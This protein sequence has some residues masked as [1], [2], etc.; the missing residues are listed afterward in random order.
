MAEPVSS[1]RPSNGLRRVFVIATIAALTLSVGACGTSGRALR[2]PK[3]GASAP[4]RKNAGSTVP[5]NP[6]GSNT[7]AG[8]Q[9]RSTAFT[10][11]T[12]SWK[13]GQSIPKQFTCDGVNTSPPFS[14]S[15]IP[16]GTSE[17]VFVVTNQNV[18]NQ[19]LWL[20]AGIGPAT[21]SISQGGV[22]AGAIQIVNSSGSARWS[23]PCPTSGSN[24][25][26]FALYALSSPSGLTTRSSFSD[27]NAAIAKSS[28]ASVITGTYSR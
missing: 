25:Y 12:S 11:T 16:A 20:M 5:A 13:T 9:I 4:A 10:L 3:P 18:A 19:T 27:V 21:I 7:T 14:I 26:E 28:S 24:V 22:P 2:D 1:P 17:L 8:A 15:G 6:S 23:G